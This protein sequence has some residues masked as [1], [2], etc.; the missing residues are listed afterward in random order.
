MKS[1]KIEK[2]WGN[3]EQFCHNEKVTVKILN[4]NPHE[5]LSL[6]YHH[7]RDEFWKVIEGTGNIIIGNEKQVAN[8]DDEFIIHRE[9][10]HQITTNDSSLS[11]LEISFGDFDEDDIVRLED[12]YNRITVNDSK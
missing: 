7:H 11:L 8:R 10:K 12:K 6:Q 9:T 4:V 2:P 3:F 5:A 1:F